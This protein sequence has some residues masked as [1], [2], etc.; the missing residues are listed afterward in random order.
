VEEAQDKICPSHKVYE[1]ETAEKAVYDQLY[2][3]Y[4]KL[5]FAFGRSDGAVGEVLPELIRLAEK[6]NKASA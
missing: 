4:K 3:L 5:Y 2:P 1:P 6:V